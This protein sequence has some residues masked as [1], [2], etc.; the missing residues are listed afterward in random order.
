MHPF[1]YSI[2][3]L[4]NAL[5]TLPRQ[6]SLLLPT[7]TTLSPWTHPHSPKRPEHLS[8]IYAQRL[9]SNAPK[10][11]SMIHAQIITSKPLNRSA[12]ASHKPQRSIQWAVD[13]PNPAHM[14]NPIPNS[15]FVGGIVHTPYPASTVSPRPDSCPSA[16]AATTTSTIRT[17]PKNPLA[18]L[19]LRSWWDMVAQFLDLGFVSSG[20]ASQEMIPLR[21][22]RRGR[23]KPLPLLPV[24]NLEQRV[25]R[26]EPPPKPQAPAKI[27]DHNAAILL[28]A[29]FS[30]LEKRIS[31]RRG[32]TALFN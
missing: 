21:R 29:P 18:H 4:H 3:Y 2:V 7:L 31:E 27:L 22:I 6:I 19:N 8:V 16:G 13:P 9:T 23:N 14:V 5:F 10:R 32:K 11:V 30:L 26:Y 1:L 25:L 12:K 28:Q 17:N 20:D 15:R 24:S